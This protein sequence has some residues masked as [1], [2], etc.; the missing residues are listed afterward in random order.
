LAKFY[1]KIKKKASNLKLF[2][3]YCKITG[4]HYV[5]E[6]PNFVAQPGEEVLQSVL[7]RSSP[8]GQNNRDL[9][10]LIARARDSVQGDTGVYYYTQ[11]G[12]TGVG[13]AYTDYGYTGIQGVTGMHVVSGDSI[14]GINSRTTEL[15]AG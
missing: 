12:L 9:N 15:G 4:R 6:S 8:L 3:F 14:Q 5:R 11:Q 1:N 13:N 10:H 7:T 2:E